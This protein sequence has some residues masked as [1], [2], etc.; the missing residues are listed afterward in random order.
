MTKIASGKGGPIRW[1]LDAQGPALAFL[2]DSN[3]KLL[4]GYSLKATGFDWGKAFLPKRFDFYVE[5]RPF[6]YPRHRPGFFLNKARRM[7]VVKGIVSRLSITRGWDPWSTDKPPF[8]LIVEWKKLNP[9]KYKNRGDY[10]ASQTGLI[11]D[12]R[13]NAKRAVME[14]IDEMNSDGKFIPLVE[15]GTARKTA[16]AG[17]SVRATVGSD[18]QRIQVKVPLGHVSNITVSNVI[19][20]A[21]SWEVTW[22]AKRFKQHL[23][24]RLGKRGLSVGPGQVVTTRAVASVAER[25]TYG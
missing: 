13:A 16:I 9:T 7:G 17:F 14:V 10:G 12:M 19:K 18:K 25:A 21:P 24:D 11:S 20:T 22:M 23:V 2:K 4:I 1:A 5:R 15:S 6:P 3:R 8:A